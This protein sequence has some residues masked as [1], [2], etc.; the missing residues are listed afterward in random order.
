MKFGEYLEKNQP[1]VYKTFTNAV[2]TNRVSHAY[3]LSGEAGAP[4]KETALFLAQSLLCDKPNPLACESCRTCLRIEHGNYADFL[5]LDGENGTIK[6]DEIQDIVGN[7]T[8]TPL[9]SKGIMIYI[10]NLAENMTPEA[11]N[12]LLK[13]LEEPTKNTYAI[14]TTENEARVL[15][16]IVSRCETIRMVLAP[17][18]EVIAEAK[19]EGAAE[20]DAELLSYFCNSGALLA[21]EAKKADYRDAKAS[22]EVTLQALNGTSAEAVFAFENEIIP[23][24]SSKEDARYFLDMLALAFKDAI[25]QKEKQRIVL[26]SY[27]KLIVPL[28][29]KLPTLEENLLEIMKVRSQ[30]DLNI[31]ISLLLE[32]LIHAI[33]RSD[34]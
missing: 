10:I 18:E 5:L 14:L 4:L 17:R 31:S 23:S 34:L 28:A 1:L 30:L 12:S 29:E 25:A 11:I 8:R 15:P 33:A 9:E 26:A 6:K 22:F 24:L 19:E 20:D 13:F 7:F 16:T 2:A 32:H 27:A 21:K 3:L